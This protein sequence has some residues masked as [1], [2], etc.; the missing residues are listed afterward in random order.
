[1]RADDSHD[2]LLLHGPQ[3]I[4]SEKIVKKLYFYC[5]N[6]SGELDDD[7]IVIPDGDCFLMIKMIPTSP[8]HSPFL[9]QCVRV[10]GRILIRGREKPFREPDPRPRATL[11]QVRL[12]KVRDPDPHLRDS[13]TSESITRP[14]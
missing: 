4:L 12:G 7:M 1:M 8:S 14:S 5:I 9:E 6:D 3:G 2:D 13:I 11:G 10:W